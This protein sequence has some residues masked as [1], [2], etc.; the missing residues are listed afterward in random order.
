M[1]QRNM[2]PKGGGHTSWKSVLW[3]MR[4]ECALAKI[5]FLPHVIQSFIHSS[6]PAEEGLIKVALKVDEKQ[7]TRREE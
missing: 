7:R 3:M 5:I 1:K 2:M 6:I 4:R